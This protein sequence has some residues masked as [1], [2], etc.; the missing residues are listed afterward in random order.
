[1]VQV[2]FLGTG[3]AMNGAGRAHSCYW[4]D[5]GRGAWAL[6]FGPTALMQCKRLGREPD[7]LEAVF[8]THLHGDHIGG[9]A[10]L[11]VDLQYRVRRRRPLIIAGP[12]GT[13]ARVNLL[14]ESAYPSILEHGLPFPLVYRQW[15]VPGTVEVA[16]RRVTAI[17]AQHDQHSVA[18][19]LRV[20]TGG[21]TLCFSGDTGWQ[22]SLAALAAG[23]DLF[24]CECS[25]ATRGYWGHLS[26]EEIGAHR[27]ELTPRRLVLTHLS[28]P[29]RAAAGEAAAGLD[30]TVADDGLVLSVEAFGG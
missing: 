5:D 2:T 9:L 3:D 21:V 17:R 14:R 26:V 1:M 13:E 28:E 11:L 10:V 8:L 15:A 4:I 27:A 19:S 16:G 22:P 12:P 23:A 25:G 18:T 6:D 20:D 29:A 24:V 30:A 7:E